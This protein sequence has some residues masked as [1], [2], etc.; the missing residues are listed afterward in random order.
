MCGG[1]GGGEGIVL[2][3]VR[4]TFEQL[5]VLPSTLWESSCILKLLSA[6]FCTMKRTGRGVFT[7]DG[8]SSHQN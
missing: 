6:R 2:E 3:P 7:N 4:D 1:G 5:E 8:S